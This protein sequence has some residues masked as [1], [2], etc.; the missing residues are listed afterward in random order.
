VEAG[1]G[2]ATREALGHGPNLHPV[3]DVVFQCGLHWVVTLQASW[4]GIIFWHTNNNAAASAM[5]FNRCISVTAKGIN[6]RGEWI[7]TTDL[8][9]PNLTSHFQQIV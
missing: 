1:S 2:G 9:A 4:D 7:R 5:P 8:L 6:G 3:P